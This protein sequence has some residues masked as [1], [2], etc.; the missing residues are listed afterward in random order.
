V[1]VTDANG[2]DNSKTFNISQPNVL[3]LTGTATDPTC[4][5]GSNG[6]I[7]LSVS[8]GTGSY[9]YAW[10]NSA[11][12]QNISGVAAANY[13]VTVT[14]ANGCTKTKSFSVA[15]PSAINVTG[16]VTNVA[17]SGGNTGAIDIT[18]SGGTGA[19]SYAWSNSANTQDVS[20]LAAGSY[21]VTVTDANNCTQTKAFTISQSGSLTIT[22]TVSNVT[23]FGGNNGAIN[24]SVNGGNPPYTYAWSN[25]ANTQNIS[26]LTAGTYTLTVTDG[27]GCTVVKAIVVGQASDI[28]IADNIT[29]A[30][31]YNGNNGAIDIT[32]SGGTGAYSYAW[33]N[34]TN[35]QD[36]S[37][38]SAGSYSV[39]VTDANG[40]TKSASFTVGQAANIV[41]SETVTDPTCNGG[42]N[43]A[44]AL[45]VSGGTGSY[46]YA[47]SNSANTQNISGIAAATYTV[48]VTDANGCTKTKSFSVAEPSAINVTGN[49]T[50]VACSGGN[51]GAIDITVSGG[52]GAYSYAWSNSANT[53]DVS[54]LAAGSYTVTVTDANNCTQTKAFTISQSGSLTITETMSNVT[55]FGG[56]NGVIN[57]SVNGGNPPYTYAWSNSANTQNIS[58]LTA[59]TYTLT[60]TDG[61]G[62]TVVKAIVVGQASDITIA[63][64]I[65]NATCYNGNNGAIDITVSGGTGA[66]SY[67]WS[68]NTNNQDVSGLSAGSYSVTVTDANG[69][70]KSASFTVGQAANIVISETVTDPTCNGGSNGAIA[71]SVSG[72]TGTYSYS[73]SNSANTQNISGIAAATYTVTVTDA[74]GCTKTKSFSVA[75]PSAISVT[76]NVTNV[77]CSGGNTGTIDITVS[78]GTGAYSYAWSNNANTQDISGLAAGSYTVTVTDANNCTQTKAFTI[79]QSG[80][81]TITETMS[82]VTCFGG[83]N[84]VINTSVNGG[85]PPYTYAW[86]N[87]ANT[88]NISG[89]TAGTY[90]LTVTDGQGCTVV[91]AI[92]VGQASDIT[93]ADNITNATCYN[94]NNG[95]IDITVSGGTGA[96]SYA[97]SNNTN[98]QDVSGLSAGSYSVTVTDANGCTKSASFTVGQAANIVIS[99]TVTDPTCNGGSNGAIALSVSGGTGSYSYAWSNSANTQNISGIT[100]ATY[101]VTVTDANGCTKTKSFSVAEPSAISVTANVTNVACSGGN[102]GAIDITVSGGTGAYSYAWSNNV[103]TQDVSGLAAGSYTVTVTDA[104]NCT[105]TKAFTISQSGSLT[106]TETVSNVT[107]FGGNNGA[108]NTSVNGGNPPYTYAWSNSANTQNISG[109]TAGTYTLTVTDNS[110]CS[111]IDTMIVIEPLAINTSNITN[112]VLCSGDSTGSGILTVSGGTP[113]YSYAWPNTA[114]NQ[115]TQTATGLSAGTYVYSITDNNSCLLI[116]SLVINEPL[117]VLIA[118]SSVNILC[119]GDSSGSISLQV[120]GGVSPYTYSWPNSGNTNSS[121]NLPAGT[122]I[123]TVSDANGCAV[124]KSITLTEPQPLSVSMILNNV[125]CFGDNTGGAT[126][127]VSGGVPTFNYLW[128]NNNTTAN[129]INLQAGV[130][131]VTVSDSNACSVFDSVNISE[132]VALSV[133]DSI[134]HVDCFGNNTGEIHLNTSGGSPGYSY[135]W[136]NS[137][138]NSDIYN[139][140][141][142]LY[143]V[144]VTDA[145]GCLYLDSFQLNAPSTLVALDSIIDLPCF[146]GND[147]EVHLNIS[148]G[149]QPYQY[150]WQ[151]A[152]NTT[153]SQSSLTAGSYAYTITDNNNCSVSDSSIVSQ[154]IQLVASISSPKQED[155]GAGNGSALINI[156]GGTSPYQYQ[157]NNGHTD[158]LN[159][160]LHGGVHFVTVTDINNCTLNDSVVVTIDYT[161]GGPNANLQTTNPTCYGDENGTATSSPT[162]GQNPYSFIWSNGDITNTADTLAAGLYFVTITDNYG[163]FTVDS[164]TI[165]P[166]LLMNPRI[167]GNA[168][169]CKGDSVLLTVTSVGASNLDWAHYASGDSAWVAP[170]SDSVFV[171]YALNPDKCME[172]DSFLVKVNALPEVEIKGNESVCYLESV[173]LVAE[174]NTAS[175]YVWNNGKTTQTIVANGSGVLVYNVTVTD[176]NGCKAKNHL[177][178]KLN[179]LEKPTAQFDTTSSPKYPSQYTFE[180]YSFDNIAHWVWDF[181]DNETSEMQNPVH[182]YDN[183][184]VYYVELIV[185]NELEC[186]DT[187]ALEIE[188]RE[189]I[190]IPNVF[191]PNNDGFNDVFII[192]TSGIDEFTLVIYNRWGTE[193]FR[194]TAPKVSWDGNALSGR[195]APEG[196]YFYDLKAIGSENYS[197]TG[198]VTLIRK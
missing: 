28:T 69:C 64:N 158:S 122:H 89:L 5:G 193:L 95:A 139:L 19:Y 2:C 45:S 100:A 54:G 165:I 16:N 97:W 15:E 84:G 44:I 132:P 140:Q 75:E 50:N 178:F 68:N 112:H 29:N 131:Y 34:N 80:S 51:T 52:T 8:G 136:S 78:G 144:S 190:L 35:N 47:W 191:T 76:G 181:G 198:S 10:S 71:L 58:G 118:D 3:S 170:T 46:S 195:E 150:A 128:S 120:N 117:P 154:P 6:A 149:T 56:N 18:V 11:N 94:G 82:N 147:G 57:T 30:T 146:G 113:G 87:S 124:S 31:C 105:Q 180:D 9:S 143:S 169:I 152:A 111:T 21:T 25:S 194:T 60:V 189:S 196:T 175:S 59:G 4:N 40:C 27:Q 107:C 14:D 39:T 171:V 91:K 186:Y 110:N 123:I 17:C 48:T 102:T 108:I 74:N 106:I 145:N 188:I 65:T 174:S 72:G 125:A 119:A 184:G 148:G 86:S 126:V 104:N 88:Q 70:T 138:V 142:G 62:C 23:C 20:G 33:S 49:V 63:D 12:T 182:N 67:A 137:Q 172:V 81:L 85:N 133:A 115:S 13:T 135:T 22:E 7:A 130:Y 24:T 183:P 66:Y 160:N 167:H 173:D 127:S 37:G 177:P 155:C 90:T 83:N 92:V 163:C 114:N 32:V 156:T 101:T 164:V 103:N 41:I 26:G 153:S 162:G 168:T 121:A 109:L 176:G 151:G 157:W 55:C 141:A 116:D 1:T 98:N 187:S 53:Q 129:I 185:Q 42:S 166:A 134:L 197:R 159:I 77:A 38:L 99:E 43:G 79:S 61:Q 192:P 36:V 93:I 73:W 161:T 96:Y 179:I